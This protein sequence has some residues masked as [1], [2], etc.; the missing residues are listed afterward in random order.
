M[1]NFNSTSTGVNTKYTST[2]TKGSNSYVVTTTPIPT[3]NYDVEVTKLLTDLKDRKG[4]EVRTS[5]LYD[6]FE[7][8]TSTYNQDEFS[9]LS[10][11]S[12]QIWKPTDINNLELSINEIKAL[13]PIIVPVPQRH[14]SLIPEW[15][16][17]RR[18][19]STM[20]YSKGVG[21]NI[22]FFVKDE[23]TGK[24]L[25]IVELSS[26]FGSLG[27]R[28]RFI[29]WSREDRYNRKMLGHTA[30]GS[31]I[32]SVQPFGFN[33]LGGKLMSMLLT[34]KVVR[35]E[36]ENR[37]GQKLVGI[38][39]TSLYG[40]DGKPT[41]YDGMKQWI[42]IGE[43][44]GK[45]FI[46][47]NQEIYKVWKD[48]LK[49]NFPKEYEKAST[50]SAPKQKI[51]QLVFKKLGLKSKDFHH[52]YK[53]GVYFSKFY[54]DSFEFL[55]G[56][57]TEVGDELFDSSI[58]GLVSSWKN[59]AIRHFKTLFKRDRVST[60]TTFYC[61]ILNLTWEQTLFNY[62]GIK[63]ETLAPLKTKSVKGFI[64]DTVFNVFLSNCYTSN[65]K[66]NLVE[67]KTKVKNIVPIYFSG[68]NSHLIETLYFSSFF[69]TFRGLS[70]SITVAKV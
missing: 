12:E 20:S 7:E 67:V 44:T 52:G 38:T 24:I 62:L 18:M 64:S 70:A 56:N 21:R 39:T 2:T 8:V 54:Q 33:F 26:D 59:R 40:N 30:V 32:V 15:I 63:T 68:I 13:K 19:V 61:D 65:A 42:N 53:R 14:K 45:T 23:V 47:P 27:V 31:T 58:D 48:W 5:T 66:P 29:G 43:T 3:F 9:Y 50:S 37:Y 25:G 28:D 36:W 4:V 55:K 1:S 51:I 10:Y 49:V 6:K 16:D 35:D 46:K 11:L 57:T 69:R 41:Q 22:K 60:K 17:F 34:S